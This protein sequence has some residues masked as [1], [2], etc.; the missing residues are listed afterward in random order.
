M[1]TA[2]PSKVGSTTRTTRP[3]WIYSR[4]WTRCGSQRTCGAC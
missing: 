4:S 1:R 3:S 2:S